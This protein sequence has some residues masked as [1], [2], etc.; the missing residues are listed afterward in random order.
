VATLILPPSHP[1]YV[2]YLNG[3]QTWHPQISP[4]AS[5]N[6]IIIETVFHESYHYYSALD[7]IAQ[8][9]LGLEF[10]ESLTYSCDDVVNACKCGTSTARKLHE[11]YLQIQDEFD[12]A[13][14]IE[15]QIVYPPVNC[16]NKQ[17]YAG[18][19]QT[20]HIDSSCTEFLARLNPL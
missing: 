3:W 12:N 9:K 8:I 5:V 18:F 7:T 15:S 19:W 4:P 2:Q 16:Y 11:E 10:L 17:S 14:N 6:N 13:Y 1:D 20:F